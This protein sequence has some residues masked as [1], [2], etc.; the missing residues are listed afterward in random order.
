MFVILLSGCNIQSKSKSVKVESPVVKLTSSDVTMED[1]TEADHLTDRKFNSV[2]EVYYYHYNMILSTDKSELRKSYVDLS[3]KDV[4]ESAQYFTMSIV[5][6]P[7]EPHCFES[8]EAANYIYKDGSR[9]IDWE[10][11]FSGGTYIFTESDYKEMLTCFPTMLNDCSKI[12]DDS[13]A[14]K[15]S[16]AKIATQLYFLIDID[17]KTEENKE[18]LYF[19]L[20]ESLLSF[21]LTLLYLKQ[22][23]E[24]PKFMSGEPYTTYFRKWGF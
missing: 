10:T 5:F 18:N 1:A 7:R 13:S 14:L 12:K 15:E 4:E 8:F 24:L 9:Y 19:N 2:Q 17:E 21:N 3:P 20:K 16:A 11:T 6:A 22:M 23:N